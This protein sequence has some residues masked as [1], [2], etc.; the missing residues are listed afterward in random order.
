M[1]RA[2][3]MLQEI[4]ESGYGYK[5]SEGK[6]H[7]NKGAAKKLVFV[8]QYDQSIPEDQGFCKS[9]PSGRFEMSVDN[10]SALEQFKIGHQYYIDLTPVEQS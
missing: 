4:A 1:V 7:V 10:P 2:K 6:Y 3:F 9:T 5:D 8:P